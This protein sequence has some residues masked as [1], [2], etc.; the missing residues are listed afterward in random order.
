MMDYEVTI[1]PQKR[2]LTKLQGL[3]YENIWTKSAFVN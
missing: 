1:N 2:N 3:S